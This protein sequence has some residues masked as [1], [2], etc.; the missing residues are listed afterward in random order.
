MKLATLSAIPFADANN[1]KN[2][3]V[4]VGWDTNIRIYRISQYCGTTYGK[5]VGVPCMGMYRI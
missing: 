2:R 5:N 1:Y 3:S 4:V